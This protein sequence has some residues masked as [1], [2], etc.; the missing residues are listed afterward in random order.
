MLQRASS[1]EPLLCAECGRV[2]GPGAYGG[3]AYRSDIEEDGDPPEIAFFCP[4]CAEL[5]FET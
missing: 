1:L 4:T 3:R 5:E 2:A